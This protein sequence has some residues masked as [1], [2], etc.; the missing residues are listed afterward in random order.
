MYH[1]PPWLTGLG[2]LHRRR[3]Q[4]RRGVLAVEAASGLRTVPEIRH[5]EGGREGPHVEE[6]G[7][8]TPHHLVDPKPDE[9]HPHAHPSELLERPRLHPPAD[10]PLV[11][12]Q[13]PPFHSEVAVA[14]ELHLEPP[15]SP[16]HVILDSF[17]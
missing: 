8:V 1:S 17:G 9:Q 15:V 7:G 3:Q 13:V 14:A 11:P 16:Q 6:E 2:V 4:R 10:P 5:R 12:E